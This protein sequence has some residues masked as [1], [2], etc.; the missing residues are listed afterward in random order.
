MEN[1]C[2]LWNKGT[3]LR[4]EPECW[5][6]LAF[7]CFVRARCSHEL[8]SRPR[9]SFLLFLCRPNEEHTQ[10]GGEGRD[11]VKYSRIVGDNGK[12]VC[13][14]WNGLVWVEIVY[15]DSAKKGCRWTLV[16]FS[17][18]SCSK[19]ML[20]LWGVL[21]DRFLTSW[22]GNLSTPKPRSVHLDSNRQCIPGKQ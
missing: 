9:V 6:C 21:L 19:E 15:W 14:C 1:G 3:K 7:A 20:E 4:A 13:S 8:K 17:A 22:R 2:P 5:S 18:A 12:C 16:V 11:A 10:K